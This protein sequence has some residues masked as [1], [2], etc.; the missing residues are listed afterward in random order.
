MK[1]LKFKNKKAAGFGSYGWSGESPKHMTQELEACGFEILEE[2]LGVLWKPD[3]AA[4]ELCREF[5]RKL[6]AKL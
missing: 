2:G 5:G 6:A 3:E 4:L 1:G